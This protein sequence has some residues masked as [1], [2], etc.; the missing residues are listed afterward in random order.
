MVKGTDNPNS[1]F[2]KEGFKE[3]LHLLGYQV[4]EEGLGKAILE[5]IQTQS[6]AELSANL[7]MSTFGLRLWMI[8]LGIKNPRKV[9]GANNPYGLYG[10][11]NREFT[12]FIRR[13]KVLG[14]K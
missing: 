8:K 7:K 5:R 11:P 10:N 1:L 13:G 12:T 6:T 3:N 2:K 14:G 9:G 4:T